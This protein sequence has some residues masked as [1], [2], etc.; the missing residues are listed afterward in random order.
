MG[1]DGVACVCMHVALSQVWDDSRTPLPHRSLT[2]LHFFESRYSH[3]ALAGTCSLLSTSGTVSSVNNSTLQGPQLCWL[4]NTTQSFLAP[5]SQLD[6]CIVP[7]HAAAML[8]QRCCLP[9]AK[10]LILYSPSHPV[11]TRWIAILSI[12]ALSPAVYLD[13]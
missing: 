13:C 10:S 9:G 5:Q 11:L 3:A 1:Y 12:F 6:A 2:A 8:V 4:S 7:A